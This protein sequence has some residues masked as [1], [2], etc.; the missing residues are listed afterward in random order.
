V[1]RTDAGQTRH[2][3]RSG[4]LAGSCQ[5]AGHRSIPSSASSAT[6]ML[7]SATARSE[8][9]HP[10][11][12]GRHAQGRVAPDGVAGRRVDLANSMPARS[13][14]RLA[15][16]LNYGSMIAS[17]DAERSQRRPRHRAQVAVAVLP[18]GSRPTPAHA[19]DGGP[20]LAMPHGLAAPA[21]RLIVSDDRVA[22]DAT[23]FWAAA[24]QWLRS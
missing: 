20:L 1:A 13:T 12:R 2:I 21:A 5:E 8:R 11:L 16:R 15:I 23:W 24:R 10:Q 3:G 18:P 14:S 4:A 19:P 7:E 22:S 17:P 6:I 9:A